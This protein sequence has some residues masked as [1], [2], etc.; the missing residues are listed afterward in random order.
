MLPHGTG[1]T[2]RVAVFAK[3]EKATEA[4]AAGADIVGAEDLAAQVEGGMLDF[5]AAI[6]TPDMMGVVGKLGRVLG[7]RGLM[8][9]PKAGTVTFD[10]AKAVQDM[11]AG[12]VEYRTDKFG[13]IHLIVGKKSF[14][15]EKLVGNYSE[16][17][18]EIVR[19]KPAAAKGKYLRTITMTTHHGSRRP[20]GHLQDPLRGRRSLEE[21]S[22]GGGPGGGRGQ[23]LAPRPGHCGRRISREV[24]RPFCFPVRLRAAGYPAP[25]ARMAPM[26]S[27]RKAGIVALALGAA[28]VFAGIVLSGEGA[29]ATAP[30]A[31]QP[32]PAQTSS[33]ATALPNVPIL[34]YHYVDD[35]PPDAGPQ[36]AA[37]TVSAAQF[38]AEMDYLA[39]NGYHPVTLEDVFESM[40]GQ[41]VLPS[42]PVAITFDDGGLDNYTVAFP[43]LKRHGFRATFFVITG[44]VGGRLCMTW[45]QLRTMHAAGMAIESHTAAHSDLR[46]VD[47]AL[48]A[49][50]LEASR[51]A[52]ARELGEDARILS[53]PQG[54]YNRTVIAATR[55]AGYAGAVTTR[56]WWTQSS[57]SCFELQRTRVSPGESLAAFARVLKGRGRGSIR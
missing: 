42:N 14:D 55:A 53:Y 7:P 16:V 35:T 30:G 56:L 45:D 28:G 50:E 27:T 20:A 5:D 34:M 33:A 48:L 22:L 51:A 54:R 9:N 36:A 4:E 25:L 46:R 47:A 13:V 11:K 29:S 23:R 40:S 38:E 39:D 24:R 2:V 15:A 21:D 17:L 6:A 57:P 49:T 52:L 3:G 31:V 8:P 1:K 18:G 32:L 41:Q 44:Y 12:K 10:V 19:A 26:L 43:I 37:L